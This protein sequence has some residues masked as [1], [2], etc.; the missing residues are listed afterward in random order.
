MD[1]E[2][3]F[4]LNILSG[5]NEQHVLILQC[6]VS[7]RTI[8][9]AFNINRDDLKGTVFAHTMNDGS[10]DEGFLCDSFSCLEKRANA[11]D[12]LANLI[13]TRTENGTFDLY[14]ILIASN[15]R[16]NTYRIFVSYTK[17]AC[18]EL[19]DGI[20]GILSAILANDTNRLGI[21]ITCKTTCVTYECTKTLILLHLIIHRSLN[22]T[23][24]IDQAIVGSNNNNIIV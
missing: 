8:Q 11:I 2:R 4:F 5:R 1:C 16:I 17:R 19:V 6:Y 7:Y 10:S 13:H 14:H 20:N 21:S 12:I 23:C 22:L 3:L 9:N 18:I 24:D 15:D